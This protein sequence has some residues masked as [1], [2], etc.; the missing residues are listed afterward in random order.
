MTDVRAIDAAPGTPAT[1]EQ[2]AQLLRRARPMLSLLASLY[3]TIT[4]CLVVWVATPVAVFGWRP[5]V[6]LSG[7]MQPAVR[8]GDI[9]LL[10]DAPATQLPIGSIVVFDDPQTGTSVLHRVVEAADGAY[11]T[12]GDA[13]TSVDPTPVRHEQV[14]GQGRLLVP[15]V[16]APVAWFQQRRLGLFAAWVGSV[17]ASAALARR[18]RGRADGRAR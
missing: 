2:V 18:P 9:I 8:T 17:V 11:T 13:N 16:G 15:L 5:Q 14:R 4:L 1:T 12:K 6:V 3:L 7:S 10:A